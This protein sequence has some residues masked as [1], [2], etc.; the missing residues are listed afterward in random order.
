MLTREDRAGLTQ[1]QRQAALQEE[2]PVVSP[3]KLS[4]VAAGQNNHVWALEKNP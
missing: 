1:S 4:P 2:K 3:A